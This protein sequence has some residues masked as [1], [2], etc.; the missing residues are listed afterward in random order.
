M[1]HMVQGRQYS[2]RTVYKPS[3]TEIESE[4]DSRS[5]LDLLYEVEVD[6]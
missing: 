1:E 5:Q 4:T 2:V 6:G 3:I